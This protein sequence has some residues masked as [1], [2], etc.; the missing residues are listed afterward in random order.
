MKKPKK[1]TNVTKDDQTAKTA[2]RINKDDH[3]QT[4][5]MTKDDQ[6]AITDE[7]TKK[8]T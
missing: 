4:K 6:T 5:K 8:M 7:E 1:M 2:E 3:D